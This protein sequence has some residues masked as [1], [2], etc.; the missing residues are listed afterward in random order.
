MQ[1][2]WDQVACLDELVDD[3]SQDIDE[4]EVLIH[5]VDTDL[6]V[7]QASGFHLCFWSNEHQDAIQDDLGFA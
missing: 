2:S 5:F 7:F 6:Y 4:A 3:V 1:G